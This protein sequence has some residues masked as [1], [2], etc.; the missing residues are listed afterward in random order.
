MSVCLILLKKI[1]VVTIEDDNDDAVSKEQI[2][3]KAPQ[4]SA[5]KNE[6]RRRFPVTTPKSKSNTK[7]S[8]SNSSKVWKAKHRLPHLAKLDTKLCTSDSKD[9]SIFIVL[10]ILFLNNCSNFITLFRTDHTARRKS[11]IYE[12]PDE[13]ARC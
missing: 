10:R 5:S 7:F 9:V 2:P 13:S 12:T 11:E 4:L 3:P 1:E 8:P 6:V